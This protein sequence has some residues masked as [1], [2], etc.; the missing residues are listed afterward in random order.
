MG[1]MSNDG[2]D[3]SDDISWFGIPMMSPVTL[4][5]PYQPQNDAQ[6]ILI[7]TLNQAS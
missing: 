5:A 7:Y 3:T 6:F 1:G 4:T 2:H